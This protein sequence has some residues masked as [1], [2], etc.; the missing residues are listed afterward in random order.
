VQGES[1]SDEHGQE[2]QHSVF[3]PGALYD[4]R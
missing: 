4:D 3:V 1:I 2:P